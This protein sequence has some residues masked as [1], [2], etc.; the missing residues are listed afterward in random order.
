MD[1]ATEQTDTDT[2]PESMTEDE[3]RKLVAKKV[4]KLTD[5]F[6]TVFGYKLVATY[7]LSCLF[8]HHNQGYEKHFDKGDKETSLFWG[9]DAG[10]LQLM[11]KELSDIYCGP[12]DFL[13]EDC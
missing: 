11:L 7:A 2:T 4:E 5:K 3:M 6:D 12:E 10:Q 8:A 13:C 1:N 9:R